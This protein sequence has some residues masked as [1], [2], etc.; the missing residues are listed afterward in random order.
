[1]LLGAQWYWWSPDWSNSSW[2]LVELVHQATPRESLCSQ[3]RAMRHVRAEIGA[4]G[5]LLW[6]TGPDVWGHC[7]HRP[8]RSWAEMAPHCAGVNYGAKGFA[9][10][11]CHDESS[12]R[13]RK[14]FFFFYLEI[15]DLP[16][17]EMKLETMKL[18]KDVLVSSFLPHVSFLCINFPECRF[19]LKTSSC[20][21]WHSVNLLHCWNKLWTGGYLQLLINYSQSFFLML[22]KIMTVQNIPWEKG[23][24]QN[25]ESTSGH[26]ASDH[27]RFTLS[28]STWVILAFFRP[29]A[30]ETGQFLRLYYSPSGQIYITVDWG[31]G[32]IWLRRGRRALL[33][34]Q[35]SPA[36]RIW[37]GIRVE[38]WDRGCVFSRSLPSSLCVHRL[39]RVPAWWALK[40]SFCIIK[41]VSADWHVLQWEVNAHGSRS[42]SVSSGACYDLLQ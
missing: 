30:N 38:W 42:P 20:G 35:R 12:G 28:V 8:V 5:D 33:P 18:Q 29:A 6:H 32:A 16:E 26:M 11:I 27:H 36:D 34:R 40:T 14:T 19:L 3:A 17:K 10:T 25:S 15:Y 13:R 7:G 41:A 24:N 4:N 9:R 22:P 21:C 39:S 2:N 37:R 31:G 1:M 23:E